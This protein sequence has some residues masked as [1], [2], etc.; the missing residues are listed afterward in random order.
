MKLPQIDTEG[1]KGHSLSK[2]NLKMPKMLLD[3]P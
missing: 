3:W 2:N 1:G